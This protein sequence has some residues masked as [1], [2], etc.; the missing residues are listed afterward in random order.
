MY[1]FVN[2]FVLIFVFFLFLCLGWYGILVV[3]LGSLYNVYKL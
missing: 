1:V 2:L 3:G